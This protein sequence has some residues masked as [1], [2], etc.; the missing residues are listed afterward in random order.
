MAAWPPAAQVQP[1][2]STR[3]STR[4]PV[5]SDSHDQLCCGVAR[6]HV[7]C[8]LSPSPLPPGALAHALAV[9]FTL[10]V[11]AANIWL[12]WFLNARAASCNHLFAHCTQF[13]LAVKYLLASLTGSPRCAQPCVAAGSAT[14]AIPT[15]TGLRFPSSS[16][17]ASSRGGAGVMVCCASA[18][19]V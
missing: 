18:A 5:Y 3:T 8:W 9:A 12:I 17:R 7:T 14:Q 4:A 15:A 6:H 13:K 1:V 19:N 16:R 10:T 2:Y 11:T